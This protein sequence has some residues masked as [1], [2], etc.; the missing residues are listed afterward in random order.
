[1]KKSDTYKLFVPAKVEEKIRYLIRKYPHTE[2]SGILFITHTGSF[3]TNDLE[4]HCEDLFPMDLGS[5]GFTEFQMNEEVASYMA[6]N[7][8]LFDCDLALCHSH[9]TMGAFF[10]GQDVET[11]QLEGNDTNCFISLI[12]DTRGTYQ[13]AITRKIKAEHEVTIRQVD[14]G[15]EFFGDGKV[16]L[17]D[18][19]PEPPQVKMFS[20]DVIEYFMLDVQR[21]TVNNPFDYLDARFEII[22]DRKRKAVNVPSTSFPGLRVVTGNDDENQ[23]PWDEDDRFGMFNNEPTYQQQFEG[24]GNEKEQKTEKTT[25]ELDNELM[26]FTPDE[27]MVE[28]AV[29]KMIIMS[30]SANIESLNLDVWIEKRMKPLYDKVFSASDEMEELTGVNAF[31]SWSDFI[32]EFSVTNFIDP[33]V[34]CEAIA[35]NE[36]FYYSVV[37]KAMS[38]FLEKYEGMNRYVDG[39]LRTLSRYYL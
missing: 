4:I 7:I 20:K 3:E 34:S 38:E 8:E 39:Y 28:T 9:H 1:M 35:N 32:V 14:V 21:E 33:A 15:Y 27:K 19:S 30:L 2:W 10:S 17:E 13:A 12:V 23:Q 11:L 26:N 31:E 18:A 6:E 16:M 37:A 36:D 22:E 5:S 25:E 24:Q 29:S